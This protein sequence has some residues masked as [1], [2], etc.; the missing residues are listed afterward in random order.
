MILV[1]II[2][3]CCIFI[4]LGAG[5]MAALSDLR[6]FTIPNHYSLVIV[7]SFIVAYFIL[8]FSKH[9]GI[10]YSFSSHILA[11]LVMFVLTAVLFA[12]RTIGAA[13]S[14]L[15][16]AFAFWVGLNPGIIA[17]LFYTTVAGGI[18]GLATLVLR[19]W[20]PVKAPKPG[21]WI[22]QAQAGENKVPYGVAI[23]CGAL[24]SF[25][26]LGYFDMEALRSF[27]L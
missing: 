8:W 17:L 4:A 1:L 23:A 5:V 11:A 2:F 19:K 15:A 6:G 22:A 20:K 14:K 3:L 21:T 18:M 25:V 26:K 24:A 16:T 10:F 7:V 13:D 12:T 27:L 9:E